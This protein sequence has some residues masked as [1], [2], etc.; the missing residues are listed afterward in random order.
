VSEDFIEKK[1]AD[2]GEEV[3]GHYLPDSQVEQLE[4][5]D[6][7]GHYL[8]DSAAADPDVEGHYLPDSQ[9]EGQLEA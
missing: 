6:V 2:D 1:A 9:V 7:E 3:E 4:D 5:K 8:P